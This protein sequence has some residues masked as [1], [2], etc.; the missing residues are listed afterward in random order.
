ME[1][2]ASC[3]PGMSP[4]LSEDLRALLEPCAYPG[5]VT[6]VALIETHISWVLLA[7]AFAYKI[8]R[9]VHYPFVDQRQLSQRRWLCEEELRLNRRF[10]PELYLDVVAVTRE[11][12]GLRIGGS[13]EAI[14]YAVRMRRFDRDA[15]LDALLRSGGIA[16]EELARFGQHLAQLHAQLPRASEHDPWGAAPAVRDLVLRNLEEARAAAAQIG[17]DFGAN[18]LEA[19]LRSA[20]MRAAEA[21]E[22]RRAQGCVRECH[23]DLHARNLVRLHGELVA[24]DCIEFEPAFRWIDVADETALLQVDLEARGCATHAWAFWNAYLT[25]SGDYAAHAVLDLYKAHRALVR[26]KVAA[27]NLHGRTDEETLALR[28][29]FHALI[30]RARQALSA[31]P[32]SLVLMSGL[33][34][35]G[36]SWLGLRVAR[37]AGLVHVRSDIER[38]RLAGLP[39]AA[40]SGS[41]PGGGLYG[42]ARTREV[43]ARLLECARAILDGGYGALID[44]TF[45][46]HEERADFQ[47]LAA[48]QGVPLLVLQCRA[49]EAVL[50]ARLAER[51]QAGTDPSE[52]DARVLDWQI[53][54]QEP[55]TAQEGPQCIELWTDRGDPLTTA[56]RSIARQH[57][58]SS[59]S[60]DGPGE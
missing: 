57:E 6:S 43:Y 5:E 45:L 18:R 59:V 16:P 50:R 30:D 33:S 42:E 60:P 22:L 54:R 31:R 14:E 23:G 8:K 38:K 4:S 21:L 53:A 1:G 51:A 56:L 36:K 26:A 17:E 24:F 39:A 40:R 11:A 46:R 20:W 27:L 52:A 28:R 12:A 49:P 37:H 58:T 2:S 3:R 13:G 41:A 47:R 55:V 32:R 29:E 10:A 19:G 34:G 35:S 15:E 9:P 44:A 48:A 25:Q 7:G